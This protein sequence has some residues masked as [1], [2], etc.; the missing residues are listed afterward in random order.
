[1]NVIGAGPGDDEPLQAGMVFAIEP[2]LYA[3]QLN[4]AVFLEDLVLVTDKGYDM[5][6]RGMPYTVDEVETV[7]M[8]KALSRLP[9]IVELL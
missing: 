2:V 1:M 7:M 8:Q 6:S 5:L 9:I 4:F 3:K